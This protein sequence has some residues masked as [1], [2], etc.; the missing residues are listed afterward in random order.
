MSCAIFL[1]KG[2][3][4]PG[5][6]RGMWKVRQA[7]GLCVRLCKRPA[8]RRSNL[9]L[10]YSKNQIGGILVGYN[11]RSEKRK[12]EKRWAKEVQS[13]RD[14]GMTCEQ[15]CAMYD[16]EVEQFHKDR[17][18][19]EKTVL[20]VPENLW[21]S[22]LGIGSSD[23]YFQNENENLEIIIQNALN[24]RCESMT[25]QD[26]RILFLF[27]RGLNQPQI[28]AQLGISQQAISKHLTKIKKFLL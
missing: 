26:K 15:I 19:R 4:N 5:I 22:I 2:A 10:V 14:A 23:L 8:P 1:L 6:M 20:G 11:H 9:I 13:Y 28:A 16:F 21:E 12:F 17:V 18:F 7:L 25:A 3:G 27:L 24:S